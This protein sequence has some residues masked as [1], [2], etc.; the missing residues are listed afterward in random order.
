VLRLREL[1]AQLHHHQGHSHGPL[2]VGG[3]GVGKCTAGLN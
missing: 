3:M 1:R 2:W